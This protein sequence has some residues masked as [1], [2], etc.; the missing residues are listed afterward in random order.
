MNFNSIPNSIIKRQKFG[1]FRF[2]LLLSRT[3][4]SSAWSYFL[5]YGTTESRLSR[6]QT[7]EPTIF[8]VIAKRKIVENLATSWLI[9]GNTGRLWWRKQ[10]A[11]ISVIDRVNTISSFFILWFFY[12]SISYAFFAPFF[13]LSSTS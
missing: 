13:R 2:L 11:R 6:V 5:T 1:K 3:S 7:I 4:I 12:L 8:T 10:R 9:S